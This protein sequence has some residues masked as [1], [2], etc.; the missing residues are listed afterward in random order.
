M[1][2][3]LFYLCCRD[4]PSLAPFVVFLPAD[5]ITH[6]IK[7]YTYLTHIP[8]PINWVHFSILIATYVQWCSI[9]FQNVYFPIITSDN[10]PTGPSKILLTFLPAPLYFRARTSPCP[11]AKAMIKFPYNCRECWF[12][13]SHRNA[14][15]KRFSLQGSPGSVPFAHSF[16]LPQA[17]AKSRLKQN[18]CLRACRLQIIPVL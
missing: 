7:C 18:V 2:H 11:C 12:Q 6:S 1:V 15:F 17:T 5:L 8:L 14:E 16:R 13:K 9:R 10:Q 4:K 3:A